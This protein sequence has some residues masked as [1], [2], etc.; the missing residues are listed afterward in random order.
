MLQVVASNAPSVIKP[1][2][3]FAQQDFDELEYAEFVVALEKLMD[4]LYAASLTE[5]C[6]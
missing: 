3:R 6:T 2:L 4:D 1:T 5:R